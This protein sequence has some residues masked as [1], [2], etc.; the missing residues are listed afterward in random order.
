MQTIVID[1]LAFHLAVIVPSFQDLLPGGDFNG[2]LH[3]FT[4][5]DN[6]ASSRNIVDIRRIQNI[7][8]R[9]DASCDLIY[10]KVM[11]A[12]VRKITVDELYA[13]TQHC[14]HEFY[15][16]C[17]RDWEGRDPLFGN[18]ILPYFQSAVYTDI[19]T[20][21]YW[22]D[23]TRPEI[24]GAQFSTNKY[25]GIFKWLRMYLAVGII[26]SS[27]SISMPLVDMRANP[28]QAYNVLQGL[29][30]RQ[31]PIMRAFPP[32]EKMIIVDQALLDG[33]Q[34]YLKS[35]GNQLN[36]IQLYANGVPVYSID[37][38]MLMVDPMWG[39]VIQELYGQPYSAAILTLRNNFIF[40]TD[41]NYGEGPNEDQALMVWYE[42]SKLSWFYQMFMK[43]GTQIALPEHVVFA[44][45]S[46]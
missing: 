43:A 31:N 1:Q 40:G 46:V 19:T 5:M 29:I 23:I 13:A 20:N 45:P 15:Q 3:E 33:Y 17:L 36:V 14:K 8:Q 39:P 38:I 35:I 11:G 30:D 34:K 12:D 32:G 7:M 41:K 25:D 2:T 18:K 28:T 21:S 44:I 26:P 42:N 16:G 4:L 10:K 24:D 9:R 22:G 27:Q 6:V 37:G